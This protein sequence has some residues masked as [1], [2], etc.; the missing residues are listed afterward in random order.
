MRNNGKKL[1]RLLAA[2]LLAFGHDA[3]ADSLSG[4]DTRRGDDQHQRREYADRREY[5]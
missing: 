3:V 4:G 1:A 5:A 2:A